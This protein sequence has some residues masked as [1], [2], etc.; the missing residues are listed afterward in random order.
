M[1]CYSCNAISQIHFVINDRIDIPDEKCIAMCCNQGL[2]NLPSTFLSDNPRENLERFIG[3]RH[4]EIIR[5]LSDD[6]KDQ[7]F[8]CARCW[9]YVKKD[10]QFSTHIFYVNL[11][12]YPSPCQ[13]RCSYCDVYT[14][15]CNSLK[16]VKE[17]P[18]VS[19]AYEN[20]FETLKLAKKIGIVI[21]QET[22]WQVSCGEI[23]IH[24]YK[25][26]MLDLVRGEKICFYTNAFIF[27]KDIARELHDNPA[28]AINLSIDAGTAD[29][30]RK[31]KRVDNFNHVLENLKAYRKASYSSRRQIPLKYIVMPGINDSEEDFRAFVDIVKLLNVE[32]ISIARD[33][34][35]K[36][37][38]PLIDGFFS[39]QVESAARLLAICSF[40]GLGIGYFHEYTDEEQKC[41]IFLASKLLENMR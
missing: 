20:V 28:A 15:E 38:P 4:L 31:V 32:F 25:K 14:D 29:T 22:R 16:Y 8:A 18:A 23:T 24:P 13:C 37:E 35:V 11:S 2:E 10:W 30:W 41:V 19:A 36:R 9:Q 33:L 6:A 26:E 1:N 21:H 39:K 34:G 40:N 5:G 3:M 17:T 27:D 12:I 7:D